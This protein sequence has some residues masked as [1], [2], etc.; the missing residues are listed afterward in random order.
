MIAIVNMYDLAYALHKVRVAADR[1]NGL[2]PQLENVLVKAD[3][4]KQVV[5]LACANG[6]MLGEATIGAEVGGSFRKMMPGRPGCLLHARK[7]SYFPLSV[8]LEAKM[9]NPAEMFPAYEMVFPK[10]LPLWDIPLNENMFSSVARFKKNFGKEGPLDIYLSVSRGGTCLEVMADKCQS[11][12]EFPE[13]FEF[14]ENP[15]FICM[16]LHWLSMIMSVARVETEV[17]MC[18]YD[19]GAPILFYA[20]GR[21]KWLL[22]PAYDQSN[23]QTR[24]VETK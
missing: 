5:T 24:V 4:D 7:I 1:S 22:M 17:R 20:G 16:K 13:E 14:I 12:E 19:G 10:R 9:L 6:F 11:R 15:V 21:T 3:A 8:S 18:Y 23:Y 2:R